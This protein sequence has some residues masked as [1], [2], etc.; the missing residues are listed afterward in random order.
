MNRLSKVNPEQASG[1]AKE[2]LDGVKAKLGMVPN[3]M[4]A[5]ASSPAVLDAYQQFSGAL[6][7]GSLSPKTREQIALAVGQVSGCDYCVAA[8]SAIGK[9]SGLTPEQIRDSRLGTAVDKRT[10]AALRLALRIVETRGEVSDLDISS[11]R[12]ADLDDGAIA[13]VA[14]NTALNLFTNYF[15]HIADTEIDFPRAEPL[16]GHGVNATQECAC[17]N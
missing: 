1:R 17:R 8:H 12:G 5:M 16:E 4:R 3:M 15:N 2:L 6:S 13:E 11:A 9:M 10:E 14:A 7:K